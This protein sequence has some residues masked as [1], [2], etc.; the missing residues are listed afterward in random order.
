MSVMLPHLVAAGSCRFG[1]FRQGIDEDGIRCTSQGLTNIIALMPDANKWSPVRPPARPLGRHSRPSQEKR[2]GKVRS[3]TIQ[4]QKKI[5]AFLP[6]SIL[7]P[8]LLI[9]HQA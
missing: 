6:G 1:P 5:P 2:Y 9:G 4:I 3:R 7:L 8:E